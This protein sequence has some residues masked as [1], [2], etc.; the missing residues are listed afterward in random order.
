MTNSHI[1]NQQK[2]LL[3]H[4]QEQQQLNDHPLP[5]LPYNPDACFY[6][7]TPRSTDTN[8]IIA[9]GSGIY[10]PPSAF[11]AP[12]TT[13]SR[14]FAYMP[15]NYTFNDN[16]SKAVNITAAKEA[17]F[18]TKEIEREIKLQS[19]ELKRELKLQSKEI[20][21]ELKL[22]AKEAMKSLK[23]SVT[24]AGSSG[25]S[26]GT[27]SSV[28]EQQK[29]LDAHKA[30]VQECIDQ[31][32]AYRLAKQQYRDQKRQI[33]EENNRHGRHGRHGQH[34][35]GGGPL[36][37]PIKIVEGVVRALAPPSSSS[38]SSTSSCSSSTPSQG[39]QQRPVVTIAPA[40][41]PAQT[42][43]PAQPVYQQ[44]HQLQ[45]QQQYQ[46]QY[47]QHPHDQHHT[48][49]HLRQQ[50]EHVSTAQQGDKKVVN[51][52]PL[53]VYSMTNMSIMDSVSSFSPSS[54]APVSTSTLSSAAVAAPSAPPMMA[55][56]A[57]TATPLVMS[58]SVNGG[59]G[60]GGD[61]NDNLDNS[62]PPPPYE[63]TESRR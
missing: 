58:Q 8:A 44:Q 23:T 1:D 7:P 57:A 17:K 21:E 14:P 24:N 2:M 26:T 6:P 36:V 31:E 35:A 22:Q 52:D 16:T 48:Q 33:R 43:Y 32:T 54:S 29:Q 38:S 53:L 4:Q 46:Q 9:N 11:P 13:S 45:Y 50:Q 39:H 15:D 49:A 47:R 28:V 30:Y 27:S 63:V 40:P 34:S 19:K 3:K 20:K 55:I 42:Y 12:G 10:P 60:G 37:L 59:G 41:P 51:P 56:V 18:Q 62:V 61:D 5:Q 25:S